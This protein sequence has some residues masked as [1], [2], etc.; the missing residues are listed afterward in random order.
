MI[1]P[2]TTRSQVISAKILRQMK[3]A[4]GDL[5]DGQD[6][7]GH[8][9]PSES[10]SGAGTDNERSDRLETQQTPPFRPFADLPPLPDDLNEAFESFKLAI[11]RHKTAGWLEISRDDVLLTLD[12]LKALA[13]APA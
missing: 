13:A 8:A 6:M 12:S 3:I 9:D 2:I 10:D 7:N 4:D 1:P 5:A 11:L